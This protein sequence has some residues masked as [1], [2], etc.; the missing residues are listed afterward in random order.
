M[1]RLKL[2]LFDMDGLMIDSERLAFNCWKNTLQKYGEDVT[3][4]EYVGYSGHRYD[5]IRVLFQQKRPWFHQF[6]EFEKESDLDFMNAIDAGVPLKPGLHELLDALDEKGI[7]KVI[8]SSS[9]NEHVER[10]LKPSGI[11]ARFAGVIGGMKVKHSKPKPDIFL[12]ACETY[13]VRPED[14]IVF[15]DSIAGVMASIA[16]NIPVICVP[17]MRPLPEELAAQCYAVCPTL[18]EAIPLIDDFD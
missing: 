6:E 2:A 15:E 11:K 9:S 5:E 8:V 14:C 13:G 10:T 1:S 17:D 4:E 18:A 16:A 12:L 7:Q 3:E